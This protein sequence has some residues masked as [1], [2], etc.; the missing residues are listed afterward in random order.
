MDDC[1]GDF[2]EYWLASVLTFWFWNSTA[3]PQAGALL[4]EYEI[5][6]WRSY[7]V[8]ITIRITYFCS[9]R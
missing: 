6:I 1:L 2:A 3:W 5:F 9:L 8:D 4:L 7:V